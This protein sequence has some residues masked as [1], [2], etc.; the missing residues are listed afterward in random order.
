MRSFHRA[1]SRVHLALTTPLSG[2]FHMV[3]KAQFGTSPLALLSPSERLRLIPLLEGQSAVLTGESDTLAPQQ[4]LPN[5]ASHPPFAP[6]PLYSHIGFDC[7][8]EL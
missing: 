4:Q 8:V 3:P 5:P 6:E 2:H 7:I 1:H